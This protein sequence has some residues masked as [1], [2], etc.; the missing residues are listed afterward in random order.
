MNTKNKHISDSCKR[1]YILQ[2]NE[3]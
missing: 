3:T 2:R 1:Y